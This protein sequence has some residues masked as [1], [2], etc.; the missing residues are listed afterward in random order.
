MGFRVSWIAFHGI[1]KSRVLERVGL[2]DT[3]EADSVNE[4][5]LSGAE[6]PGG[7]FILFSN[8]VE[9]ISPKRLASL[10]RDCRVVACQVHEGVMFSR[11]FFYE[12]GVSSCE[13]TH[14]SENGIYDLAI[15]GS[16]PPE[17]QSVRDRLMR[18]QNQ[19]GGEDAEVDHVFEIPVE[20]AAAICGYRHDQGKFDWGEPQFSKLEFQ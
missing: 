6:V 17:F 4:S 13:I 5:P 20:T 12:R 11:A 16:P 1:G 18:E 19:D 9:F 14:E 8:D 3:G 15:L 10:S 7:W 2:R